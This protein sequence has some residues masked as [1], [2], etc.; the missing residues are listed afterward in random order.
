MVA[1]VPASSASRESKVMNANETML[2]CSILGTGKEVAGDAMRS[3]AK[4]SFVELVKGARAGSQTH[5]F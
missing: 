2:P 5:N 1:A 3:Q 4:N